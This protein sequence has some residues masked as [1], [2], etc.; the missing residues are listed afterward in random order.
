M[1][2]TSLLFALLAGAAFSL[3]AHASDIG[4]SVSIGQPGF[5]GQ[6]D[7]GGYPPPRLIYRQ[8][9]MIEPMPFAGAPVYLRVPPGHA[10]HWKRYCGRY[11]ACGQRVYFVRDDWYQGVYAPRYRERHGDRDWRGDRGDR[12]GYEE[13][14]GWE[15]GGPEHGHGGHGHGR[16]HGR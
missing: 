1:K 8:P 4:V 16:G 7:I 13:R 9:V 3:S 11:D 15:R 2:R 12:D 14:G 6:I 10:K 5:Y